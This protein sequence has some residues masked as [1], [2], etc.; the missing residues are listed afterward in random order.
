MTLQERDYQRA[1][2]AIKDIFSDWKTKDTGVDI[3]PE[4]NAFNIIL[5]LSGKLKFVDFFTVDCDSDDDESSSALSNLTA[6]L[7]QKLNDTMLTF[8]DGKQMY[9]AF[10]CDT[11]YVGICFITD[12]TKFRENYA[13]ITSEEINFPF[14]IDKRVD[15]T[16]GHLYIRYQL[17]EDTFASLHMKCS[18]SNMTKIN[19]TF[20]DYIRVAKKLNLK[21][22]MTVNQN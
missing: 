9:E 16:R 19:N 15:T 14:C 21:I 22:N 4:I 5:L 10:Q 12:V 11:D 8:T 13:D 2:S 6:D 20:L 18:K 1:Y 3:H 7:C 17:G